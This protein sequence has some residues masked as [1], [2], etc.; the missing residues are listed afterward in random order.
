VPGTKDWQP[1]P[2]HRE[3]LNDLATNLTTMAGSRSARLDGVREAMRLAGVR[4]GEPVML[5]GHSQGGLVALRAAEQLTRDGSFAVTHVV[6]AGSPIGRMPVPSSVSVLALENRYD[7]VPQLDGRPSPPDANRV[8]VVFDA[9]NHDVGLNHALAS[10]YVP[11]GSVVDNDADASL[12]AWRE[13]A[14]AFLAAPGEPVDVRTTVWD[15]SNGR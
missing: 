2:R 1:D 15:I 8:T 5:V 4:A 6:T 3:H 14:A 10:A 9:Q 13:G 11:A 7:V 12:T